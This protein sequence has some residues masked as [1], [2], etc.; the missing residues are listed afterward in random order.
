MKGGH[1]HWW[2]ASLF[3]PLLGIAWVVWFWLPG[4]LQRLPHLGG[5]TFA[6]LFA[7]GF[8]GFFALLGLAAGATSA[9][10]VGASIDWLLRRIGIGAIAAMVMATLVNLL[11]LWQ[12]TDILQARYPGLRA[13]AVVKPAS[14]KASRVPDPAGNGATANPCA[15]SPPTDKK[16]RANWEAEC[17]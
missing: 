13:G 17:R 10:L 7:L 9:T 8:F 16:E 1:P 6:P 14:D 2:F 12:A 4:M 11:A 3:C 5:D 15:I